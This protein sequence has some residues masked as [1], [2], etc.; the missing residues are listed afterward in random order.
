MYVLA[1]FTVHWF[2]EFV[3]FDFYVHISHLCVTCSITGLWFAIFEI[4]SGLCSDVSQ[5]STVTV[6]ACTHCHEVLLLH[7]STAGGVLINTYVCMGR[8]TLVVLV[9]LCM[10]RGNYPKVVGHPNLVYGYCILPFVISL[11]TC[12]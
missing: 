9:V 11:Y 10:P 6:S 1:N 7:S 5:D 8:P 3:N 2:G 4:H 12:S